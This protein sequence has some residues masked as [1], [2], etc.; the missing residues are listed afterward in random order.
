M[1]V[2]TEQAVAKA[3]DETI[4]AVAES[5]LMRLSNGLSQFQVA[6]KVENALKEL[7]KLQDGEIPNYS[8]EWVALFYL[9]WYQS[10]HIN[11]TYSIIKESRVFLNDRLHVVDFGCGALAMQ[12][13]LT[14]AAVDAMEQDQLLTEIR[15]DSIDTSESMINIG[16]NVWEQF[17]QEVD[18]KPNLAHVRQ[19]YEILDTRTHSSVDVPVWGDGCLVSAIHAVYKKNLPQ[20]QKALN[21]LVNR[22]EPSMWFATTHQYNTGLLWNLWNSNNGVYRRQIIQSDKHATL[23]GICGSTSEW[24]RMLRSRIS[25]VPNVTKKKNGYPIREYLS[26]DV[27]WSRPGAAVLRYE[28]QRP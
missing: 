19:A 27:R 10:S 24:R 4:A 11:L 22:H 15:I 12:F 16:R 9:T 25:N 2:L 14:L 20:V 13:G 1:D 3:L 18:S 26:N 5:E 8:D 7:E 6:M 28:R 23:D 21:Y 17:T